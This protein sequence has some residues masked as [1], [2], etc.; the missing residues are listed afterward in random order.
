[1]KKRAAFGGFVAYALVDMQGSNLDRLLQ[2][3]RRNRADIARFGVDY[4]SCRDRSSKSR[5]R[6]REASRTTSAFGSL[7]ELRR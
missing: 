4:V 3:A 1:M 2:S 5:K 6:S 7:P